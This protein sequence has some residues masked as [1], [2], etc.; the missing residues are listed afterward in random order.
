[1]RINELLDRLP[2]ADFRFGGRTLPSYLVTGALGVVT[3]TLVITALA[4]I[5]RLHLIV[6]LAVVP[7]SV[8]AFAALGLA[9][10]R[11]FGRENH[12]LWEGVFA[13]LGAA[14]LVGIA[15][16][17]EPARYVDLAATG[18]CAMLAWGR[19]GCTMAGCCHGIRSVIGICYPRECGVHGRRLPVQLVE[20]V[21][22]IALGMVAGVLAI[23]GAPFAATT[24]VLIAYGVVR[25]ALESLR[26]DE[27]WRVCGI[28]EGA[29][30]SMIA[31]VVGI[32]LAESDVAPRELAVGT[33]AA[34]LV[35]VLWVGSRAWL[36]VPPVVSSEQHVELIR[37]GEA[38]ARS[39]ECARRV[40]PYKIGAQRTDAPG[41]SAI[42]LTIASERTALSAA[43]AAIVLEVVATSA[44]LAR[45]P[46][47]PVQVP[48]GFEVVLDATRLELSQAQ[49]P[50]GYFGLDQ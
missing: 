33:G 5:T 25:L 35:L 21:L 28:T 42:V 17:V 7:A 44:G 50:T 24:W 10:R 9:R 38:I 31:I 36:H 13:T 11:V 30:G 46:L 8:A 49:R 23:F 43:E 4:T 22:W 15:A 27:R 3:A 34:L 39:S 18:L 47:S 26:G 45:G 19:L 40:G 48:D 1:M 29:L 32:M 14:W 6:A 41:A 20:L 2:R 37:I 12:V 16:D